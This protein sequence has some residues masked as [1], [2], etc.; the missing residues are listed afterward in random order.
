[1]PKEPHEL[2][3]VALQEDPTL[4]ELLARR[5][6]GVSFRGLRANRASVLRFANPSEVRPDIVFTAEGT[7]WVVT[8]VQNKI[9]GDKPRAWAL[10]LSILFHKHKAWGDL[11]ILTA[12]PSVARWA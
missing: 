8:E 1:M 6:A 12:S 4:L 2:A 10:G 9:D 11:V 5:L 3:V 7:P